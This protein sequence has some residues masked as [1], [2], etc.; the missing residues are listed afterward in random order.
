MAR[1]RH[2]DPRPE[3]VGNWWEI[4]VYQDEYIDGRRMRKRKRVRLAPAL[5]PV[6]AVQKLKD[7]YLRPINQG[8]ISE[9]G[10]TV[11]E[12]FVRTV[13]LETKMKLL[14]CSTQERYGGIIKHYLIPA[15]G[16]MC[17]RDI[18]PLRVQTFVLAFRIE[19]P[20]SQPHLSEGKRMKALSRESVDKIRDV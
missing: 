7:E 2:Q 10:A 16:S 1:R 5:M 8:L 15:F 14:T 13:Y 19:E 11:F 17:L 6:R 4:R 18:T 12:S 20:N 9:G 3:K